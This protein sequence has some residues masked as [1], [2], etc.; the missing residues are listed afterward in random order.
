M[1]DGWSDGTQHYIAAEA[2]FKTIVNGKE[3]VQQTML[4]M[5]P[6]FSGRIHGMQAKEQS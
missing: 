5:A 2:S 6:L 3:D 4:S 1:F